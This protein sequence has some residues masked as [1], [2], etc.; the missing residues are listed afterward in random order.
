MFTDKIDP[1]ISSGVATIGGKDVISKDIGIFSWSCTNDER[2]LHTQKL[3]NVLYFP[4]SSFNILSATSL[5]EFMKDDEV[6][7]L[8]TKLNILFLLGI[9][10]STKRQ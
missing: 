10:G 3:N 6:T 4:Y 5:D 8:P 2:K 1:I 7:C 9:L